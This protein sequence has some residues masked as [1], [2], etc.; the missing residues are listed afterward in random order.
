[1]HAVPGGP[2]DTNPDKPLPPR[3]VEALEAKYNLD[4]SIWDQYVSFFTNLLQ[5]DLGQS[6]DRNVPVTEVFRGGAA[7][8][9][10]QLGLSAFAFALVVGLGFG[11]VTA[12]RQNSFIDYVG[13]GFTTLG[14]AVPNFVMA[15]FLIVIFAVKLHWFDVLGWEFGNYKKMVIADGSPR[16]P[17][18]VIYRAD[19]TSLDD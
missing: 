7:T 15:A 2:F 8:T 9:M 16:R 13:V 3:T 18:C 17:S 4:G 11:I 14:V 19:H 10:I 12:F 6:F 5:G 1:M